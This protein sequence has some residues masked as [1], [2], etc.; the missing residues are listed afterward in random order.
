M[1]GTANELPMFDRNGHVTQVPMTDSGDFCHASHLYMISSPAIIMAMASIHSKPTS[2]LLSPTLA[3]C[4]FTSA[5]PSNTSA[6]EWTAQAPQIDGVFAYSSNN[7]N[8]ESIAW[9]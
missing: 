9:R 8:N 5:S 1:S 2:A 4:K 6:P 3:E 7:K